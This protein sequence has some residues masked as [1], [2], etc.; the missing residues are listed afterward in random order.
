VDDAA[1]LY[2]LA[3]RAAAEVQDGM[4]LGLGTGST[5]NAFLH[6]LGARV[7]AG[8]QITGVPT[9]AR[10]KQL[11]TD[12]GIP[13]RDFDDVEAFDLGIDG[14]DEID[15]ELNL[16]KGRGG[17]L[18]YEK[19]VAKI[20][21]RYLVIASDEKRVRELGTRVSLPVEIIPYG[22][23][24][25]QARVASLAGVPTLRMV[26]DEPYLT[27]GG[28]YILDCRTGPIMDPFSLDYA[29]KASTGVVDHGLFIG[30]ATEAM[31]VDANGDVAILTA[32][33]PGD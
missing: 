8:L 15:P 32:E 27:D 23:R 5:A 7:A 21:T 19:L 29:L 24:Q 30:I 6:A 31:V 26:D 16:I 14:A 3:E 28:H 17:S 20:C 22:W 10:T 25:T 13:L 18:L 4:T 33:P 11:A 2:R 9:S 1:R 12:L